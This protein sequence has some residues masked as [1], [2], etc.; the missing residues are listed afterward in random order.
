MSYP[1][2]PGAMTTPSKADV[3]DTS[4]KQILVT[5]DPVYCHPSVQNGIF[6]GRQPPMYLILALVVTFINP[7]LG[8]FALFFSFLSY[9]SF[10]QG[11]LKYA[12]KWSQYTFLMSMIAIV[13]A[14]LM[15][16][17]LSFSLG[18][19]GYRGGHSY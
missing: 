18:S 9:R 4:S 10:T 13:F 14:I 15:G 12:E 2:H 8:P 5:R 3:Y 6:V 16:I 7:L 19:I 1:G 17:A 11:D